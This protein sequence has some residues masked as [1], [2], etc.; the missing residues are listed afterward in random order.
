MRAEVAGIS[1]MAGGDLS[2]VFAV[3]L[4]DGRACVAKLGGDAGAEAAMLRAIAA[5]G[6]PAPGVLAVDGDL[7][8][9]ERLEA[10]GGP[11]LAW[12]D[13]ARVLGKLHAAQG[14]RYGWDG[15]HRFG[16]VAVEN[17]RGDDWPAFWADH[18]LR[19]HLRHLSAG[20]AR[21]IERLADRVGEY[22]PKAPPPSLLHGDL[23]GGNVL[24]TQGGIS[25]LIDPA[26]YYGD[27][28]VDVAMLTLFDHPPSSFLDALNLEPGWRDR[29]PLYRL[30]P[31]LVH[32]RLFGSAY[33]GQV[34]D[35]L[36]VLGI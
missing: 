31:L 35:S 10:R 22:V 20:L 8:I 14:D 19:C 18:R 3:T 32:L 12:P 7:L 23:W 29:L 5:T 1:A 11:S 6:A 24:A 21:R 15:D 4:T 25:G 33:A 16:A 30:W 26:C 2:D 36:D 17:G 27:R 34:A 28:E 9:L 13:L